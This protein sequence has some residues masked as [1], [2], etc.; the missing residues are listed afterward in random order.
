[1]STIMNYGSTASP[2]DAVMEQIKQ[3]A[4]IDQAR[5]LIDVLFTPPPQSMLPLESISDSPP[6]NERSL[7][8]EMRS[9]SWH[10]VIKKRGRVHFDVYGE[11]Y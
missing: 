6:E 4:A 8:R 7:L 11:V 2:K 3:E 9:F 5:K 10:V 1:M